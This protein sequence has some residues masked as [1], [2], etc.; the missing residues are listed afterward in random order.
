MA[1]DEGVACRQA[2][3]DAVIAAMTEAGYDPPPATLLILRLWVF[4]PRCVTPEDIHE[5][6]SGVTRRIDGRE[7]D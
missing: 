6:T 5:A 4:D 2:M 1:D 7:I 3:V